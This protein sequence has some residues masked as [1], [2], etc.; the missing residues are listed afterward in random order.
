MVIINKDTEQFI[1]KLKIEVVVRIIISTLL[2]IG[3]FITLFIFQKREWQTLFVVLLSILSTLYF[4]YLLFVLTQY[5]RKI[6][7]YDKFISNMKHSSK[8]A[9][10]VIVLNKEK[11][12]YTLGFKVKVYSVKEI[13]TNKE[14]LIYIDEFHKDELIINKT[15]MVITYHSVLIEYEE[16]NNETPSE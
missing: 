6:N 8:I 10:D 16:K 4:A 9:N 5:I 12:T 3:L 13:D 15:Y 2:F 11:D 1:K 7:T 14:F